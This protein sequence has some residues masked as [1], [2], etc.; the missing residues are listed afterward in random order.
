VNVKV[1]SATEPI[2]TSEPIGRF[3]FQM[4]GAFAELD[5][6]TILATALLTKDDGWEGSHSG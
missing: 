3:I 4:L 6:E 5:R 1:K 2:D